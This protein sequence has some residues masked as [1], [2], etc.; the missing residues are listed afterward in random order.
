[1]N[2]LKRAVITVTAVAIG[3]MAFM[4][5]A[6]AAFTPI[7]SPTPAYLAGTTRIA[8]VGADGTVVGGIS[9]GTQTVT[10]DHPRHIQTVPGGGWAT[11]DCPPDTEACEPRVLPDYSTGALASMTM[12]LSAASTIFG[13]EAE[14]NPFG[15]FDM[16]ASFFSG[17]AMVGSISQGVDGF[18]GARLFAASTDTAFTKVVFSCAGCDF[19]IAQVRYK[20]GAVT[21]PEPATLTLLGAGLLALALRRRK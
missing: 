18:A 21:T 12:T 1:M 5:Q 20:T 15:V 3:V 6:Q 17:A 11:W 19:A 7:A 13:F 14:P 10:F 16:T 2:I 8:L 9:D 4:P